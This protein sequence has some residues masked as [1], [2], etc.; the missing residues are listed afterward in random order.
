MYTKFNHHRFFFL[1]KKN[2]RNIELE[3]FGR[4]IRK[5]ETS[6]E[7]EIFGVGPILGSR[8]RKFFRDIALKI[9]RHGVDSVGSRAT[10]FCANQATLGG[11]ESEF[12]K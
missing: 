10:N 2:F 3:F 9:C 7:G 5:R 1:F 11:Q 6:F 8:P 4:N 12:L